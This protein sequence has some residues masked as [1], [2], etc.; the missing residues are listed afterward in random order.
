MSFL[1]CILDQK[2]IEAQAATDRDM[3]LYKEKLHERKKKHKIEIRKLQAEKDFADSYYQD[4]I[5]QLQETM[6]QYEA[7]TTSRIKVCI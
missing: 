2:C 6:V 3:M 5:A 1:N 4:V 7:M